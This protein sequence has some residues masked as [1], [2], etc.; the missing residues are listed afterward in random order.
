MVFFTRI[1]RFHVIFGLIPFQ[2]GLSVHARCF[3]SPLSHSLIFAAI[4]KN[5]VAEE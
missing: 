4:I 1:L 2:Q 3:S 5:N